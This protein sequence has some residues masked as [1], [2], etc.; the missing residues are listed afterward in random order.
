MS[1]FEGPPFDDDDDDDDD[2]VD[3]DGDLVGSGPVG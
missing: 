3:H 2:L 1:T